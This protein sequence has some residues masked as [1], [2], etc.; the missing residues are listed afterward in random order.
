MTHRD[1]TGQQQRH[2][3]SRE[4][5]AQLTGEL[6]E[7]GTEHG[8]ECEDDDGPELLEVLLHVLPDH[9]ARLFGLFY[10]Q[11]VVLQKIRGTVGENILRY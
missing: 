6:S 1:W 10:K 7:V 11:F 5:H 9:V 2:G 3:E 8:G 4:L